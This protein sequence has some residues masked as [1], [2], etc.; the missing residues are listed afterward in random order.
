MRIG[1]VLVAM[2][3]AAF[4]AQA[5][6]GAAGGE[7]RYY[8]GDAGQTKYSPLSQI[9]ASNV[10]SLEVAWTW[11]SPDETNT[12]GKPGAFKVTPIMVKG[13]LY[14]STG[15]NEVAAI[16]P[17]SGNTLWVHDP[18]AYKLGQPTNSGWQ[19]RGV[20]YWT[21]GTDERIVIATGTLQL[22][23]LNAKTGEPYENFGT[24]GWVDLT[25]GLEREISRRMVGNNAPVAI[26]KDTIVV[27]STIFDR[28]SSPEMPPGHVRGYDVKTGALKWVFHTIPQAGEAGVET[29]E[30]DSWKYSG[31]ANVWAPMSVDEELGY[32]YLPVSTPTNDYY[33]GHRKGNNLYAESIVCVD[34]ATGQRV[35]HFQAVHHGLWDYDF[36]CAPT[37]C[38]ITV[39]GKKIKAVAAVSKQ[40]FTYVFDRKTGE[41]VWPIEERPVPQTAVPGEQTSATQPFPT[42]PPAFV[43]QG[44]TEDDLMDLTPELKAEA[45]KIASEYT[46]GPLFT[47]P[48]LLGEGGKKG[49]F[50]VP[51]AAGGAN[52]G[53]AGFDPETG[54]LYLQAADMHSLASVSKGDP[55]RVKADYLTLGPLVAPGPQGLP[56]TKPPYGVVVGIDL[57]QGEIAW[58]VA[59][60]DGPRQH[61]ALK[62]V[63]PGPLGA[64]SHGM[65]SSGGPLVTKTLLFINQAQ[66]DAVTLRVSKTELFVRAF[67]KATGAVLWEQRMELAPYGTPM[68]YEFKGKQYVVVACGGGGAPSRLVAYALP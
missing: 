10:K 68:T 62:G 18:Q 9:D 60:G 20:S 45:V 56:I 34:A 51:S 47:P 35:W 43:R 31:G 65:L 14:A 13:V 63:D 6:Q 32:V 58:K 48:T 26:V 33:G 15:M 42:K 41:P 64:T 7:W 27:G 37:L 52:W 54:M 12:G 16:D 66:L 29:W 40:G 21:D 22:I 38:D 28:P 24:G 46:M 36:P 1:L 8:G 23:A 55:N 59:H 53:G 30:N 50:Q 39:N 61:P 3:V 17:G 5:Q 49:A 57:N 44:I 4:S 67:D 2:V 11:E 19:H 25:Q